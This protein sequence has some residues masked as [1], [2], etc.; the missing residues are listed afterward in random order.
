MTYSRSACATFDN[1]FGTLQNLVAKAQAAG[2]GDDVLEAKLAEDMF[3]LE[4]QFRVAI[5]QVATALNRL[6]GSEIGLDEEAYISF[7]Q[8]AERLTAI[9]AQIAGAGEEDW[10]AHDTEVD[11]TLPNGMRFVMT[12]N[13][14]I[15]DWTLPNFYFHTS[16]A[17]GLLRAHGLSIGKADFIPHMLKYAKAPAA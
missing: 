2:M 14:Y 4:S 6:C 7:A 12:A 1:M 5:N 15:R 11:F 10:P 17:Y 13:E 16:L 3:P 8:I 9:R